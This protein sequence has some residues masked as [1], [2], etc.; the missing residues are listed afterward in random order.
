MKKIAFGIFLLSVVFVV[1]SVCAKS[2]ETLIEDRVNTFLTAYNSGDMEEV[3][4]CFDAK[5][6][7]T[8][9][10][11][12]NIGNG[13]IGMTGFDVGIADLFGLGVALMSDEDVL[14]LDDMEISIISDNRAIVQGPLSYR[15]NQKSYSGTVKL[16]LVK[17]NGDWYIS[18]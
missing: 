9:K 6:R 13:L 4:A 12:M 8:Y 16:L 5:T 14:K 1:F 15:E 3:I 18:N 10:A 7:N 11:A 2:D 17:E